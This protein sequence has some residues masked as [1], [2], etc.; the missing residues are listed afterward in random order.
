MPGAPPASAA[1]AYA[2][3]IAE[4]LVEGAWDRA[5]SAR[6]VSRAHVV[7][8]ARALACE[9]ERPARSP[10]RALRRELAPGHVARPA[11]RSSG[12]RNCARGQRLVGQRRPRRGSRAP[13]PRACGSSRRAPPWRTRSPACCPSGPACAPACSQRTSAR[14]QRRVAGRAHERAQRDRGRA[15]VR[16][17]EPEQVRVRQLLD[18]RG[19]A[20]G[21]DR[22]RDAALEV[23]RRAP[24]SPA[25]V[26]AS[27]QVGER[28]HR[29]AL[30]RTRRGA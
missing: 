10:A 25:R 14:H 7:E 8:R 16:V 1:G 9:G 30:A 23:G 28:E 27:Q 20:L 19:A 26:I 29:H 3:S 18:V 17:P 5:R 22:V 21:Q 12:P 24:V 6:S 11:P 15:H 2:R 4:P 13:P